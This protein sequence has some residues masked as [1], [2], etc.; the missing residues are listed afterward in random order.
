[1]SRETVSAG[2]DGSEMSI[3]HTEPVSPT[4]E[5]CRYFSS[6]ATAGI[7]EPNTATAPIW[8]SS[9]SSGTQFAE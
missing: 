3:T 2:D 6:S 5:F 9:R 1:M 4:F 8:P 7:G